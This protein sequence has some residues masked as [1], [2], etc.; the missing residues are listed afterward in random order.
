MAWHPVTQLCPTLCDPWTAACQAPLSMGRLQ[1]RLLEW[2]AM[3]SS[4]G[5]SWPIG[6]SD[7]QGGLACCSPWSHK[8]LDMTEQL[9][10]TEKKD[11]SQ[12]K[13]RMVPIKIIAY[14]NIVKYTPISLCIVKEMLKNHYLGFHLGLFLRFII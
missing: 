13:P 11:V 6:V 3:P 9:Q 10:W 12:L 1:V 5:S 14:W 4:R 8:E 2:V 7:G